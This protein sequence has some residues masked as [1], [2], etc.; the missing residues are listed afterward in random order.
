LNISLLNNW[1]PYNS[2]LIDKGLRLYCFSYA[3]GSAGVYK[4][5][6]NNIHGINVYPVQLPGREQR[7]G[8]SLLKSVNEIIDSIINSIYPFIEETSFAFFGH[9]MGALIAFELTRELMKRNLNLPVH[10]FVSGANAPHLPSRSPIMYNLPDKEFIQELKNYNGT[11][12][13]IFENEEFIDFLMPLLRADFSV[14]DLYEYKDGLH[15]TVPITALGGTKDPYVNEEELSA[16]KRYT[17]GPFSQIMYEGD[18]FFISTKEMLITKKIA[19]YLNINNASRTI[20]R[21][22]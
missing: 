11:V 12:P 6:I 16:W 8:E 22:Y 21:N 14:V 5:W 2:K 1:F 20:N 17:T 15:F 9:S 4:S 13:E 7:T 10:L 19:E 18:H 3:G